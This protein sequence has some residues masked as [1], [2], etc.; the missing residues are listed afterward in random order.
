MLRA[1]IRS[2]GNRAGRLLPRGLLYP[3]LPGLQVVIQV[4]VAAVE[5]GLI[6]HLDC[7]CELLYLRCSLTASVVIVEEGI[8]DPMALQEQHRF[9]Q[10][11]GWERCRNRRTSGFWRYNPCEIL[12]QRFDIGFAFLHRTSAIRAS[13]IALGLSS[14][15]SYQGFDAP[16]VAQRHPHPFEYSRADT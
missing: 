13:L 5:R 16:P 12:A 8:D 9:W 15:P 10:V 1:G 6:D 4:V 3:G 2:L 7:G 11:D 14:V